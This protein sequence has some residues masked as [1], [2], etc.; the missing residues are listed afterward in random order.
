[1]GW[2]ADAEKWN[3]RLRFLKQF[4]VF[5]FENAAVFELCMPVHGPPWT[6]HIGVLYRPSTRTVQ[7]VHW[8]RLWSFVDVWVCSPRFH[9][10]CLKL[11]SFNQIHLQDLSCFSWI[12]GPPVNIYGQFTTSVFYKP[13]DAHSYLH[14]H[15]SHHHKT[16]ASIPYAQSALMK[17]FSCN[18][19]GCL[20][21]SRTRGY[22]TSVIENYDEIT[23][24]QYIYS[25]HA[26]DINILHT[27]ANCSTV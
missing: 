8:W 11:A 2:N 13:T 26:R 18:V 27:F 19:A 22:P 16:K 3:F 5:K 7:E 23:K 6:P 12:L 14:F 17:T 1:M 25:H 4:S 21:F 24:Q 15:S 10:F 9:P 20:S